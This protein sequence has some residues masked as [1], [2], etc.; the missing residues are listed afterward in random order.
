M[1]AQILSRRGVNKNSIASKMREETWIR[2]KDAKKLG[3]VDD[4]IE[5]KATLKQR[6]EVIMSSREMDKAKQLSY[7]NNLLGEQAVTPIKTGQ[8]GQIQNYETMERLK[9]KLDVNSEDKAIAKFDELNN[10]VET[11]QNEKSELEKENK[12]LKDEKAEQVKN[13]ITTLIDNA[14]KNGQLSSEKRDELIKQGVEAP[15][16]TK[17]FL[18][19][20]PEQKQDPNNSL[21]AQFMAAQNQGGGDNKENMANEY[22]RMMKEEPENL[23]QMENSQPEKFKKMYNAWCEA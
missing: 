16:A 20:L 9:A 12:A 7:I 15:E 14:I 2:S 13:E 1:L 11:L 4:V 22:E 5:T 8:T 3:L 23:R 10:K 19:S 18:N 21:S 6:A 17:A